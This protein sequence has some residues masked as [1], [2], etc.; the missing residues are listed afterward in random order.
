MSPE[1]TDTDLDVAQGKPRPKGSLPYLTADRRPE[2]LRAWLTRALRPPEG[3]HVETFERY[4]RNDRDPCALKV[5]NGRESKTFRFARQ[6]G[7]SK[8]SRLTFLS[9]SDAWLDVPHLTSGEAEDVWAALCRLGL[10]LSEFDEVDQTRE[11]VESFLPATIPLNGYSLVPDAR[12]DALMAIRA[13]GTFG[14]GDA[15]ALVRPSD[16]DRFAQRPTRFIDSATGDQWIRPTELAAFVRWVIGV[17]PLSH[18][19]LRA[20]LREIG[21]VGQRFEDYRPPHPK[22]GLYQL[23]DELVEHVEGGQ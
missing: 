23:T 4:G 2:F 16:D 6:V 18:A 20:R 14:K 22:L 9:A 10:V 13:S 7:L 12:H 15:L 1:Y 17:E 11:W 3:W 21:I 5:A 8:N 19:T